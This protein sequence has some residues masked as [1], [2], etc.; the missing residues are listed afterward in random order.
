MGE[1]VTILTRLAVSRLL[2]T[3]AL[4]EFSFRVK[5][6]K[7]KKTSLARHRYVRMPSA[8]VIISNIS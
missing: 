8:R 7:M 3:V 1:I 4:P 2:R 5:F 6:G